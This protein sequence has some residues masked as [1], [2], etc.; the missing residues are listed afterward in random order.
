MTLSLWHLHSGYSSGALLLLRFIFSSLQYTESVK[1][2]QAGMQFR[3][4]NRAGSH[5]DSH[6]D[7]R[8]DKHLGNGLDQQ[9]RHMGA[10]RQAC[11]KE[12]SRGHIF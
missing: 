9:F 1:R 10:W 7:K 2:C 6:L 3:T 11:H 12:H 5:L 4:D 8:L